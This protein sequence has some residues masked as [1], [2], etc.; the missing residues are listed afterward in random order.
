MGYLQALQFNGCSVRHDFLR[1]QREKFPP[2]TL[3]PETIKKEQE[4]G[5]EVFREVYNTIPVMRETVSLTASCPV[6]PDGFAHESPRKASPLGPEARK[7][8]RKKSTGRGIPESLEIHSLE[9][10]IRLERTTCGLRFRC[11]AIELHRL[12]KYCSEAPSGSQGC[13]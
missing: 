4:R 13:V 2:F 9:P 3:S 6:D 1:T 12:Q 8:G 10:A 7:E 11:S 5:K